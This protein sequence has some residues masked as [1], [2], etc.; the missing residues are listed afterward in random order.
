MK[1]WHPFVLGPEFW[2]G[3]RVNRINGPRKELTAMLNSPAR[4][5][6]RVKFSS[7]NLGVP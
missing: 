7:A 1:N 4:S 5:C 2:I 6:F 3:Q